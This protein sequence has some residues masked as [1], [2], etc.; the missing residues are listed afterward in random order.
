MCQCLDGLCF[1][2]FV[3]GYSWLALLLLPQDV[4]YKVGDDL[5]NACVVYPFLLEVEPKKKNAA[6]VYTKGSLRK[7][8]SY[9]RRP[10][11]PS[12]PNARTFRGGASRAGKRRTI[13]LAVCL[14][15]S[16]LSSLPKH[17]IPLAVPQAPATPIFGMAGRTGQD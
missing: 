13:H 7:H 10:L 4:L 2:C 12:P 8:A 3:G 14:P 16:H 5:Q 6:F 15:F 1:I 9:D 17:V 11:P